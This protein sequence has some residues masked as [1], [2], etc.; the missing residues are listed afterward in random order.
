VTEATVGA[1]WGIV[2]N[3]VTRGAARLLPDIAGYAT[4]MALTPVLGA[5]EAVAIIRRACS[6]ASDST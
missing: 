4:Y 5:D 3:H 1:I 6:T 2:H